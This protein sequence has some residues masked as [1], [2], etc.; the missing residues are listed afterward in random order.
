MKLG[1]INVLKNKTSDNITLLLDDVLSELDDKIKHKFLDNLPDN[2]QI[3][4]NSAI[5][6]DSNNVK[7]LELK[8]EM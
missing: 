1:L 2:M 8:G 7:I 6:I 4:L 3:I 5:N